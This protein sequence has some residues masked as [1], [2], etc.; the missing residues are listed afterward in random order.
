MVSIRVTSKPTVGSTCSRAISSGIAVALAAWLLPAA[1]FAHPH[2]SPETEAEAELEDEGGQI[3]VYFGATSTHS[4]VNTVGKAPQ[5]ASGMLASTRASA[6]GGA[7]GLSVNMD[8][9]GAL[10]GG[11]QGVEGSFGGTF[12]LGFRSVVANNAGFFG[13]LGLGGYLLGNGAFYAS[14]LEVPQLEAGFN[15]HGDWLTLELGGRGGIVVAGRHD[16][17]ARRELRGRE[18]G[19]FAN[20]G[21]QAFQLW[22]DYSRVESP[23]TGPG[24]PV[25]VYSTTLCVLPEPLALCADARRHLGRVQDLAGPGPSDSVTY[26]GLTLALGMGMSGSEEP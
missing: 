12:T 1:A 3:L 17:G 15:I 18:H 13:R 19:L 14:R 22:L 16:L 23:H 20:L 10:G 7:D 8:A 25:D 9:F 2:D 6:R 5:T 4:R 21:N 26:L 24:T 11:S